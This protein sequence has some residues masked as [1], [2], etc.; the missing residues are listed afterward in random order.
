MGNRI[1]KVKKRD[2]AATE[3]KLLQAGIEVFSEYG[4]DGA[5]T[6]MIS[7]HAGI[8]ESLINRYFNGKE[9]LL[10]AILQGYME[11][12]RTDDLPYPPQSDVKE[13]LLAY[14]K[15]DFSEAEDKQSL[16][17]ITLSQVLLDKKFARKFKERFPFEGDPRL[18]RR[19]QDLKKRGKLRADIDAV[20]LG[21]LI[22]AQ[23]FASGIMGRLV[24][25][26]D[27]DQLEK[28]IEL[29]AATIARG[30]GP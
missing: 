18:I 2:R 8:N 19:L 13:E 23:S 30:A 28:S 14:F 20:H 22:S 27:P 11:A 25:G 26:S 10:F 12:V 5:T 15:H 3:Q 17:R 29:F 24:I 4:Y 16:I 7:K 9:G 1:A 6:K 21:L